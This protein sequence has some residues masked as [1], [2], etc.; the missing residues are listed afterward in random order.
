MSFTR[1]IYINAGENPLF[2]V[3]S[4]R[5]IKTNKTGSTHSLKNGIGA[6][7]HSELE[8]SH[9]AHNVFNLS[10]D[11]KILYCQLR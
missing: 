10:D 11:F 6:I 2:A 3:L 8:K 7:M 4:V 5:S 9:Y 1:V